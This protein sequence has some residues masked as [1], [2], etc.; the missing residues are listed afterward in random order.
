M[1][2]EKIL[3][4][5][6][7]EEILNTLQEVGQEWGRVLNEF[8]YNY[9]EFEW[10]MLGWLAGELIDCFDQAIDLIREELEQEEEE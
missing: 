5:L 9:S 4:S 1:T 7:K 2:T 8:K 3:N 10:K 6:A